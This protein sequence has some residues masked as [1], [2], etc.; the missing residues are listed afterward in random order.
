[1]AAARPTGGKLWARTVF[2]VSDVAQTRKQ[3]TRGIARGYGDM[4]IGADARRGPLAREELLPVAIQTR[5]V[6][7][8]LCDVGES[9]IAF[10]HFFPVSSG[11]LVARITG[12]LLVRYV[13]DV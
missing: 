1:M 4:A 13:S 6:L 11:K 3:E 2:R 10:A 8:K 9:S 5:C 12:E 7:G